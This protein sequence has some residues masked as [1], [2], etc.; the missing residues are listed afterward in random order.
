MKSRRVKFGRLDAREDDADTGAPT[1]STPPVD[2]EG[3]PVPKDEA[4]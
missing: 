4:P 1:P 3:A 2:A